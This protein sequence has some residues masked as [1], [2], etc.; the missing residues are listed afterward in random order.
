MGQSASLIITA[1]WVRAEVI[2]LERQVGV[3]DW[4]GIGD[5]HRATVAKV[6]QHSSE[7]QLGVSS[8]EAAYRRVLYPALGLRAA[9]VFQ[10]EIGVVAEVI[11]WGERN[12]VDAP[13]DRGQSGSGELCEAMG[14]RADEIPEH[15]GGEGPVDPAVALGEIRVVVLRAPGRG[16]SGAGGVGPRP[17]RGSGPTPPRAGRRPPTLARP[18]AC[19]TPATTRCRRRARAPRPGRWLRGGLRS[20]T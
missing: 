7:F 19:H 6:T 18:N 15:L 14:E 16:P 10:E 11:G 8:L 4:M 5:E 12:G 1:A 20:G 17:R 3:G 13:F 2:D 9:R